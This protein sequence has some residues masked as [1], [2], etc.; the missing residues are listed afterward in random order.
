MP[1]GPD[2]LRRRH[3]CCWKRRDWFSGVKC[4]YEAGPLRR[5]LVPQ[6]HRDRRGLV[7][8]QDGAAGSAGGWGNRT[9]LL[10]EVPSS[11]GESLTPTGTLSGGMTV[12]FGV[13]P[14]GQV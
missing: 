11:P 14:G 13:R 5:G 8:G 9:P 3:R 12:L 7:P 10:S 2:V 1:V 4:S 6:G